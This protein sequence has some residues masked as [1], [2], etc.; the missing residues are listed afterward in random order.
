MG[1]EFLAGGVAVMGIALITGCHDA[2]RGLRLKRAVGLAHR[3][4]E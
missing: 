3:K 4:Q 1:V 2:W